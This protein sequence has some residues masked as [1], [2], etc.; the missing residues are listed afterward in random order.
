[1][2]RLGSLPADT[3][4][5][6]LDDIFFLR[7]KLMIIMVKT[8]LDG[9]PMGDCRRKAMHENASHVEKEAMALGRHTDKFREEDESAGRSGYDFVF[10]QRVKL[11]ALM[12]KGVTKGFPMG[13]HRRTAMQEN[14]EVICQTLKFNIRSETMAFLKVA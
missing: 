5:M 7:L 10:Y 14:L 2:I 8:Y 11:L 1:M 6:N 13:S 12:V 3:R 9:G 4:E